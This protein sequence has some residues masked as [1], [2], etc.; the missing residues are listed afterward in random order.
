MA[1]AARFPGKACLQRR[2]LPDYQRRSS[3]RSPASA[4]G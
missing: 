1:E 3:R 4:T 2:V